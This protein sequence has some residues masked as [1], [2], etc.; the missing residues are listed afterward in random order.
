[1]KRCGFSGPKELPGRLLFL[2]PA[3][4]AG[5]KKCFNYASSLDFIGDRLQKNFV[6]GVQCL[7]QPLG[8]SDTNGH[9]AALHQG[10]MRLGDFGK[11]GK[12][13]LG[14]PFPTTGCPQAGAPRGTL[15]T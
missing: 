14:Q 2:Q 6:S 1:M 4:S 15:F 3:L 13:L 9:L 8:P 11:G 10:N 12:C 7:G 5:L